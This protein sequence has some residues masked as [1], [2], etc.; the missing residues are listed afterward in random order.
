MSTVC[1]MLDLDLV[2]KLAEKK[3]LSSS[4]YVPVK[5]Q[6]SYCDRPI[7]TSGSP[8]VRIFRL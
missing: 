4:A 3:A 6:C 8:E 2:G 1:N 5:D 7:A